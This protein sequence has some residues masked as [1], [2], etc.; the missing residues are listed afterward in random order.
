MIRETYEKIIAIYFKADVMWE[1]HIFSCLFDMFIQA[2]Q[3]RL[4]ASPNF[5]PSCGN[6][7]LVN[8]E[9]FSSLLNYIDKNY[10]EDLTLEMAADYVGF[11]KY[12]FLRMFKEYTGLTFHEYVLRRRIQVSQSLLTTQ[13]SITDIA[14][15]SGFNSINSF[16]RSF[17]QYTGMSPTE[18]REKKDTYDEMGYSKFII[19]SHSQEQPPQ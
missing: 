11:S 1:I 19:P 8:H 2:A 9:K 6:S 14:F 10:C 4:S 12:H 3:M 18:Y 16:S 5:D 15:E 7:S 17:R 13:K